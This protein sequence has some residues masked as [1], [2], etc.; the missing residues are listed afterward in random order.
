MAVL[1]YSD[2][3]CPYCGR[4][5]KDTLPVLEEKYVKPGLVQFAFRQFP[6]S[7]HPFARRI[8]EAAECAE[9]QD[10]FWQLHYALFEPAAPTDEATLVSKVAATGIELGTFNVCFNGQTRADVEADL[11]SGRAL[12]V[13]GTPTFFIGTL[14][15]GDQLRVRRRFVG[16]PALSAFEAALVDALKEAK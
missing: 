7:S 9:R 15:A 12:E 13:T 2:F 4:F 11:A 16:A 10:K 6:L 1:M 8:A 3:Q 5:A 14:D